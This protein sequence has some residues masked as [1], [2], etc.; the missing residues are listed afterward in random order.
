MK[1]KSRSQRL[2]SITQAKAKMYEYDVPTEY[3]IRIERDPINLFPLSIGMLG[4]SA[5]E[6]NKGIESSEKWQDIKDH[7]PFTARFFDAYKQTKL[8]SD[9]DTYSLVI[10]SAAYYLSELPGSSLLLANKL[11]VR[12][13]DL[14]GFGLDTLLVWILKGNYS[15]PINLDRSPY[16]QML[17]SIIELFQNFFANGTGAQVLFEQFQSIRAYF[18]HSGSPRQLLFVDLIGALIYKRFANSTWVTLPRYSGLTIEKWL[19]VLQKDTFIKELWPAQHRLGEKGVFSGRSAIVQMPTSSG[20]TKAI[21]IILRSAF[22]SDRARLAVIVAPFRALCHEIKDNLI[23]AFHGEGIYINELSDILQIDFSIDSLLQDVQVVIVTPEK[24]NYVLRHYPELAENI[25]LLIF[26][27][28]H[29]FDNGTRGITYELLLTS[30]K[31]GIPPAAQTILI[32]AVISN[33]DQIGRW[34]IGENF[35][36]VSGF[37]LLPT[38]RNVAFASW[39]DI[40]FGR[41]EF[42]NPNNIDAREYFVPRVIQQYNLGKKG[43]EQN[44]RIFPKKSDGREISLYLG[45]KIISKGSVAIFCGQKATVTGICSKAVDIFDRNIPLQ[46]PLMISG[47]TAE[48]QNLWHLF[49]INLGEDAPVTR[50]AK[51]GILSHHNNIPHGIRLSVEY[52]VK[53]G[54]AHFVVCTSTLAQGVNLPIRYLFVTSVYQGR[55]QIKV[56]DFQ[57]LIGRSGRSDQHTEGSIIFPDPELYDE[58]EHEGRWRWEKARVL[59]DPS[60]SEPCTSSLYSIFE[61]LLSDDGR[62]VLDIDPVELIDEY[63][64][65]YP[66]LIKR[67]NGLAEEYADKKFS[68]SGMLNQIA[69]KTHLITAI[70]SFLMANWDEEHPEFNEDALATLARRT[71]AYF[72]ADINQDDVRRDEIV[73]LFI[74]LGRNIAESVPDF[75]TRVIFGRT[76]FGLQDSLK[77]SEWLTEAINQLISAKDDTEILNTL[78][79]LF[80][81]YVQNRPFKY[82]DKPDLRER[83]VS[84]WIAGDPFVDLYQLLVDAGARIVAKTKRYKYQIEDIVDICENGFAYDGMLLIGAVIEFL[85]EMTVDGIDRLIELMMNFMKRMKYGL[86]SSNAII[87]Y[88]LG[89]SDRFVA[90]DLSTIIEDVVPNEELVIHALKGRSEQVFE[91][92]NQY[93]EYFFEVYRIVAT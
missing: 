92:L 85:R 65:N 49:A 43:R 55:E 89:F 90:M 15:Q 53:E 37:D 6:I 66:S 22:L 59:L 44:D 21:E 30:L 11:D 26:D 87:L 27:E 38:F 7:L 50:A 72:L 36:T 78:W 41:L 1:P 29:Q 8:N 48:I 91:K 31:T 33:A 82:C 18:Y 61:K 71:L 69:Y 88:E 60:N 63:N 83:L 3:H 14:E 2:L 10:G 35:E 57:N 51:L 5:A 16:R 74:K 24:L 79:P 58:H 9:I 54:L 84:K 52:A 39:P 93:P 13:I 45:L 17:S 80:A 75:R 34:L 67:L 12:K 76:L 47:N 40:R 68:F 64:Q 77:I 56:R 20:K 28:G 32:S 73:N 62:N 23:K 70:E 25:G 4:D 42:V 19:N 86:P 81:E 46:P